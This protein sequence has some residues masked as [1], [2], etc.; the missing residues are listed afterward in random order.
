MLAYL[1][2]II[3]CYFLI[4]GISVSSFASR[5]SRYFF[6]S[7]TITGE[8]SSTAI[9]FGI[10]ISPLKV[11]AMLHRR[12]S[13]T[14]AP[15]MGSPISSTTC[16]FINFCCANAPRGNNN[17]SI[18][19][20]TKRPCFLTNF[21]FSI[22]LYL[23]IKIILLFYGRISIVI[24]LFFHHFQQRL[25]ICHIYVR[26]QIPAHDTSKTIF[27]NIIKYFKIII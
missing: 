7:F 25:I 2:I 5:S 1:L 14:V 10:A 24:K 19:K 23:L 26:S 6:V 12:S 22:I 9:R 3:F 20:R 11:S 18:R 15:M 13:L 16:P 8:R 27:T 4:T 21:F 17:R